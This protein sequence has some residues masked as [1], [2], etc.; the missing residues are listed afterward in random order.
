MQTYDF[1]DDYLLWPTLHA[2]NGPE[3]T[4]PTVTIKKNPEDFEVWELGVDNKKIPFDPSENHSVEYLLDEQEEEMQPFV[5]GKTVSDI[6]GFYF[7][8]KSMEEI[9]DFASSTKPTSADGAQ[10]A[11][12]TVHF[13]DVYPRAS[14]DRYHVR[15]IQ[16]GVRHF[17]PHLIA[18]R[19]SGHGSHRRIRFQVLSEKQREILES[20]YTYFTL[21]TENYDSER[22]IHCIAKALDVPRTS[23]TCAEGKDDCAITYRRMCGRNI[24]KPKLIERFGGTIGCTIQVANLSEAPKPI[25]PSDYGGNSFK[26]KICDTGGLNEAQVATLQEISRHGF[27]NYYGAERFGSNT[28][29]SHMIGLYALRKAFASA[30]ALHFI[31][32]A[33]KSD[34]LRRCAGKLNLDDFSANTTY[35]YA[36]AL[37]LCP[38][39]HQIEREMLQVLINDPKSYKEAWECVPEESRTGYYEAVQC[40]DGIEWSRSA[41]HSSG[42]PLWLGI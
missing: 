36:L 38:R 7:T 19:V 22:A 12:G 21:R 29:P 9:C 8:R 6:V 15:S 24:D 33:E 23:L 39:S 17:W 40:Y 4:R 13:L 10:S 30:L 37:D 31:H 26:V 2:V 14:L 18:R 34:I 16:K 41:S 5:R 1:G 32:L 42:A 35:D 28:C 27:I 20:K 25:S 11:D 3:D